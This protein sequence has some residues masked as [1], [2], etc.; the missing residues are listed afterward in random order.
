VPEAPEVEVVR[1][2]LA[3][4]LTGRR[5]VSV[6]VGRERVVRR[7]SRPALIEGM[8]GARVMDVDRRGK[9]LTLALDTGRAVMI[10]LRM[11]GQVLLVDGADEAPAHTHVD[12][13][14]DDGRRMLF[15][16][17]R[18][19]GEVVVFD[20]G[21]VDRQIPELARLGP[22]PLRDG[23]DLREFRRGLRQRHRALKA[24][25]LDQSFIAGIGNI[26]ADEICHRARLRPTRPSDSLGL[27]G[28]RRLAEAIVEVLNEAVT[29]GGSTLGDAQ[30]VGVDGRGGSYQT[31]H[32]V[33][34]RAGER[35][36]TC[37]RGIVRR[38]T[39]AQRGTYHCP[40]C[41]R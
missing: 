31:A 33:H 24:L 19:F 35:C 38:S 26:Y 37:G 16:D 18:T 21:D 28:E 5:F 13:L 30:Y 2:G 32:R 11:S 3:E 4:G 10:H 23:L 1:R 22:D 17:P 9:Y 40:V 14:V 12:A 41:Q 15:V 6:S 20:P 27:V 34:A 25:L 36:G 7:T 8:T 39:V 29:A